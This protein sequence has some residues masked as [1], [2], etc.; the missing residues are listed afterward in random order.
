M[1]Y[2]FCVLP[3]LACGLKAMLLK[4]FQI[5]VCGQ[6]IAGAVSPLP[7]KLYKVQ[8]QVIYKPNYVAAGAGEQ[9]EGQNPNAKKSPSLIPLKTRER[10][11]T[12]IRFQR[13]QLVPG[14]PGF[15]KRGRLG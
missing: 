3:L 9:K 5:R 15:R 8:L 14:L 2:L 4:E 12:S 10:S 11:E 1:L 6:N 7:F 13:H